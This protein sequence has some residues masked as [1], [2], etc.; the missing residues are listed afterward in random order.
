M[1]DDQERGASIAAALL[2][3]AKTAGADAAD[4]VVSVSE[5]LS[6]SARGGALEE[7]ERA[8]SLD[9]GLR[10]LV[11]RAGEDGFAQAS[12]SASDAAAH[13]IERLAEQAVAMAREAPADAY[14]GLGEQEMSAAE[15]AAAVAGL[16]LLDD[17]PPP[18][19][20]ALLAEAVALEAA[21]LD[22]DGVDQAE[23]ASA[24]WGRGRLHLAT[25]A[26]FSAGYDASRRGRSVSAISGSADN[27][28]GMERDYAYSSARRARDL[29]GIADIGREAG[30]RAVRRRRPGKA[31]SGVF[32]V[33]FEPRVAA[34]LISALLGALNGVSVARGSSFLAEKMGEQVLP[35]AFSLIDD[36]LRP[37]GL[38][39]RPF[40]GEGSAG[41][42]K[43]LIEEGR[44]A[45]WLLD[46]SA[47]RQLGLSPNGSASRGTAGAPRP[48]ASTAWLTPGAVSADD[49]ISDIG[50]GLFVTE[51]MGGGVDPVSGQYSRGA[52]GFWIENGRIGRP[53]S[54]ATVA[55]DF[56]QMLANLSAA[57]DLVMDR[58]VAAPTVR[59]EGA[60]IAGDG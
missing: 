59:V 10:V 25:T 16:D 41:A 47:A 50:Q 14:A 13:V 38:G 33:V 51:M 20:D 8:E 26:G 39:A 46:S 17:A 42:R 24:S 54:E 49:L 3:A 23:G 57:D 4:A 31:P 55:G 1:S 53:V 5:S 15:A 35:Q 30:E 48:G 28:D 58:R 29:R 60:T 45:A 21:A 32:P 18:S 9:F 22:V 56:L 43:A 36:P 6:A 2:A 7:I 11:R 44:V 12:V 27:A 52:S 40:D 34:S 37:D 19:A